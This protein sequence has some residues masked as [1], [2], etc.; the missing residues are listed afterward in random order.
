MKFFEKIDMILV[1]LI[2]YFVCGVRTYTMF[3]KR[4]GDNN[5]ILP[6]STVVLK[7]NADLYSGITMSNAINQS[8]MLTIMKNSYQFHHL[9]P[10]PMIDFIEDIWYNW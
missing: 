2:A 3:V 1:F 5:S 6:W 7:K 8:T 4:V 10:C 9:E